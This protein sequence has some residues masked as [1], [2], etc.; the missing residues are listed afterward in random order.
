MEELDTGDLI[1]WHGCTA[2]QFDPKKLGGKATVGNTRLDA[3][4][5]IANYEDGMSIDELYD[6]F[7][8]D[9]DAMRTIIAFYESK[10]MKISA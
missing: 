2:V 7:H 6:H 8:A 5:V 10:R 9:K 4:T 1:D 3:D